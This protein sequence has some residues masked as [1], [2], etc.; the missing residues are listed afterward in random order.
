MTVNV[1]GHPSNIVVP[2]VLFSQVILEWSHLTATSS[3]L[4]IPSIFSKCSTKKLHQRIDVCQTPVPR[5]P[6]VRS[7][8]CITRVV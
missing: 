7:V 6:G 8:L 5:H 1:K 3:D 4:Q 2:S